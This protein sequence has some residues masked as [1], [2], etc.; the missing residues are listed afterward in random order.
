MPVTKITDSHPVTITEQEFFEKLAID[1]KDKGLLIELYKR[2]RE[3]SLYLQ[4]GQNSM[5]VK[6]VGDY[7]L[8]FGVFMAK[9]SFYNWGIASTTAD[10]RQPQIG[11]E[12]LS[13][14]AQLFPEGHVYKTAT[15]AGW[16]A[17][18]GQGRGSRYITISEILR[19]SDQWLALIMDTIN[20]LEQ[21]RSSGG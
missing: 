8:T 9:G 16:S 3:S 12:Y 20:K 7:E 15:R 13:R 18:I 4:P 11:E 17:K 5:I 21:A 19:V 14:L 2:A 10:L 6:Y 1:A